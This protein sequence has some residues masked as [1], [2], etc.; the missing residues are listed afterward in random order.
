MDSAPQSL[1]AEPLAVGRADLLVALGCAVAI[2]VIFSCFT[3]ISRLGAHS[4]L[5]VPDILAIRFGLSGLLLAPLI[6]KHGLGGLKLRQALN[7]AVLGGLGFVALAIYGFSAAP[8]LHGAIFMHGAMPLFAAVLAWLILKQV[9]SRR[10]LFGLALIFAGMFI[11]AWDATRN[12]T[13]TQTIGDLSLLAASLSW[14]LHA[15]FAQ[16]YNLAPMHSVAVVAFFSM[17]GYLPWYALFAEHKLFTANATDLAVQV[18]YQVIF[19]AI[20]TI[21]VYNRAVKTLGTAGTALFV[22]AVP[23]MTM[24]GAIP[25][26]GEWP[27]TIGIAGAVAVSIGMLAAVRFDGGR[28]PAKVLARSPG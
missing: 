25:L 23:P 11:I 22:A 14:C 10:G 4:S 17:L 19:G 16:R 24:L 5:A 9:P 13:M 6:V 8:A 15:V 18:I 1:P 28:A 12:A 20:I 3:L 7:L 2:V 27:S 21:L 26:L